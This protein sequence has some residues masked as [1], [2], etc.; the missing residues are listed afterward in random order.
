[1]ENKVQIT[2]CCQ[3]CGNQISNVT[4]L[5]G[6]GR[7]LSCARTGKNH[8]NYIDGRTSKQH[9]CKDCNSIINRNTSLYGGGRCHTCASTGN[10]NPMFGVR[11]TGKQNG[12]FNKRHSKETKLKLSLF[13]KGKNKG[14]NNPM[15]GKRFFGKSNPNWIDGRSY[16]KYP[17]EFNY[18]LRDKIR[19]RDNFICKGCGLSE[20]EHLKIRKTILNVH[21]IDYNKLNCS[22]NNLI[23]LC[24]LCNLTANS[25]RYYWFAYYTYLLE[26]NIYENNIS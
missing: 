25:N 17:T 6:K 19:T 14:K 15:Y 18:K 2:Y 1:M 22:E 24:Y 9:H 3:D 5:Y 10:N 11:L 16:L 20:K 13:N 4:A 21:H 26:N 23:S 12:M 8:P 7:C